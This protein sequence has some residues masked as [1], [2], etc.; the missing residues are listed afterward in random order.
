MTKEEVQTIHDL[1][2]HGLGYKKIAAVTK[3]PLNTVKAYCRRHKVDATANEEPQAFC[4]NCGKPITRTP[5]AKPRQ[6]CSDACRMLFW[7][8]H[9]DEGKPKAIY[10]FRCPYC[11]REFQSIG[12]P[13]RK[14]CSRECVANSRRKG[15]ASDGA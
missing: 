14:Y 5:N 8:N 3:L 7:S 1:Q 6:Y 11:G 15:G 4:R 2:Q 9:R 13:H 12:N 10:H